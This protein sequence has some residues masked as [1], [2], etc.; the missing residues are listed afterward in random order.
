[1]KRI[2]YI[3]DFVQGAVCVEFAFFLVAFL[4]IGFNCR[5]FIEALKAAESDRIRLQLG[6][7]LSPMKIV[8]LQ[9]DEYTF[10][11]LPVRLKN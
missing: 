7:N 5:Y 8:P 2:N 3:A 9:G 10:L 4:K 11:L 1:M 6:G